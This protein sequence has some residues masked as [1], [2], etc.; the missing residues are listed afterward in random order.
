MARK[1]HSAQNEARVILDFFFNEKGNPSLDAKIQEWLQS[2]IPGDQKDEALQEIWREQVMCVEKPEKSAYK[3]LEEIRTRLGFSASRERKIPLYRK[4]M[5][6]VAVIL[7]VFL[8][9]G[10][11]ILFTGNKGF[12]AE[13]KDGHELMAE[14]ASKTTETVIYT[15]GTAVR[16]HVELPDGSE[17]W[18]SRNGKIT[19]E[20]D[21]TTER[22]VYLEGEA[23]FSVAKQEGIPF[24]VTGNDISVKVLGTEFRMNSGDGT[25]SPEV[26][27]VRGSVEVT[28]PQHVQIMKPGDY[29][30]Y[31]KVVNE[32]LLRQVAVE[33]IAPW[34]EIELIFEN[35]PLK[36]VFRR[37]SFFYGVTFAVD[38]RIRQ[39]TKI[40]VSFDENESLEE[41]LYVIRNTCMEFDYNIQDENVTLFKN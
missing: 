36:E 1:E 33:D 4:K 17:V 11:A 21:F 29:V 37:L 40:T 31:D 7:L 13:E 3:S 28:L 24:I 16:R 41:V 5:F 32:A 19:Y 38:D 18:I 25:D 26:A 6:R 30:V 27:L 22:K 12:F 2:E 23:Y 15:T 9:V 20:G 10:G 14:F 39:E 8:T 35:V 34:K